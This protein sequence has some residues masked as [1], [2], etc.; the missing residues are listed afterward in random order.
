MGISIEIKFCVFV[1]N[2]DCDDNVILSVY[3]NVY[4]SAYPH[5]CLSMFLDS[6]LVV[7]NDSSSLPTLKA[8]TL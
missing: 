6:L 1:C 3:I 5:M 2:I 4:L 8:L 7:T